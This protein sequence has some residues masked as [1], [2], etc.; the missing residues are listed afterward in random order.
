MST[1]A[2]TFEKILDIRLRRWSDRVGALSDLQGDFRARRCT[3]DQAFTLSKM[4]RMHKEQ[5]ITL[6]LGF[7][8]VH[9]AYDRVWLP[10]LWFKLQ[11]LGLSPKFLKSLGIYVQQNHPLRACE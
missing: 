10:G 4:S 9:K 6:Y 1:V 8:E 7:I 3:L 5:S 2:K 11:G